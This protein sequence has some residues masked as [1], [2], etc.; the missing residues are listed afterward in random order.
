MLFLLVQE[1]A[2]TSHQK[3]QQHHQR[4]HQQHHQR[5]QQHHQ[6]YHQWHHHQAAAGVA[7]PPNLFTVSG[8][9]EGGY[10]YSAGASTRAPVQC[11]LQAAAGAGAGAPAGSQPAAAADS[12]GS[13]FIAGKS[14]QGVAGARVLLSSERRRYTAAAGGGGFLLPTGE[15][16]FGHSAVVDHVELRP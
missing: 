14:S 3:A 11:V 2:S 1:A 5:Y 8:C 12:C 6:R 15:A 10:Q 16:I 13:V 9:A 7:R 4:Y